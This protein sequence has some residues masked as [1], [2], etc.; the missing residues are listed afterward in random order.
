MKYD[1]IK[2]SNKNIFY[3]VNTK[4]IN[5]VEKELSLK[6]PKELM[7]FYLSIGYGYIKGSDFNINRIMDPRSIR[8]FRLRQNDFEFYPNIEIYDEFEGDK[9]IFFEGSETALISIELI[10]F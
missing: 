8:D 10:L 1:Y 3:S 6:I 2:N 7:E 9:L 5:D 4:E